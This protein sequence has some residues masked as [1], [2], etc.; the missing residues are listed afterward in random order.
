MEGSMRITKKLW[1]IPVALGL[2]AGSLAV[3]PRST[4]AFA[5]NDSQSQIV[6][7]W[8]VDADA[9]YRPHLATFHADGTMTITNPT[10]VQV[11]SSNTNDS[12]GMGVWQLENNNGQKYI[13]GTFE[14]LNATADTHHPTDTLYVSFKLTVNGDTFDGPAVAKLSTFT[15]PSH[16]S[17]SR[18]VV[19]QDAVDSL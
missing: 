15:V 17:G 16:L 14:E 18:I 11:V 13:V 4:T 12:V 19:D 6:G 10:D 9:P 7:A 2:I 1:L 3:M 8:E 5:S